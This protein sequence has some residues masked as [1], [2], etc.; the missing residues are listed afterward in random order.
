MRSVNFQ[1]VTWADLSLLCFR[2]VVGT[3]LIWGVWDNIIDPARMNEFVHFLRAHGFPIPEASARMSVWAQF[4]CGL[5]FFFGFAARCFG[6]LCALNFLVA[7]V[8]VDA[9]GGIRSAFPSA[10]LILFGLHIAAT[11]AGS[12]S[13]DKWL[14]SRLP[15]MAQ[16]WHTAKSNLRRKPNDKYC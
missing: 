15:N 13:L 4:S 6:L 12:L 8:M 14:A 2:L 11:G 1:P 9:A 16:Y 10:M 3:F 7:L 5:A